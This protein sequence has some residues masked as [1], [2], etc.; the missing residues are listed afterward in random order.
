MAELPEAL[1]AALSDHYSVRADF[2]SPV[3][4]NRGFQARVRALEKAHGS[5]KA[6][7]AAAGISP[8]TW[9]RWA[10]GKQKVSGPSLA[11]VGAAHLALIRAA[12]VAAKGAPSLIEIQADVACLSVSPHSK[13]S[14]KYNTGQKYRWFKAEELTGP[15]RRDV[16]TA[17]AAGQS[18]QTVADVLLDAIQ[19]A[20]GSRFAFEGTNVNVE[21]H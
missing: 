8:G 21:I 5:K 14:N 7:A 10:S 17:W 16:V 12:K 18:P 4:S 1:D 13:G 6:A 9:S 2:R 3:D 15:Q 20:Y 11:K 19:T